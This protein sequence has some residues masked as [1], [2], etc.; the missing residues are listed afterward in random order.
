[1]SIRYTMIQTDRLFVSRVKARDSSPIGAMIEFLPTEAA[2][3]LA[4]V[5]EGV[6]LPPLQFVI[7]EELARKLAEAIVRQ[8]D[9]TGPLEQGETL[10]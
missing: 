9:R 2:L 1:M 4:G 7:R 8:L 6:K 5:P 10:H 3:R